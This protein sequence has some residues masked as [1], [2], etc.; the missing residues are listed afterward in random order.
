MEF[1]L[2]AAA[3][4]LLIVLVEIIRARKL[5][6]AA[7]EAEKDRSC[8]PHRWRYDPKGKMRC[9]ICGQSPFHDS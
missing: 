8:P 9:T 4:F 7:P 6:E 2:I 1:F 5:R 3:N